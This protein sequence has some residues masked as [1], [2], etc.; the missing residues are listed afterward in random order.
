M[1]SKCSL[2]MAGLPDLPWDFPRQNSRNLLFLHRITV[3]GLTRINSDAQSLQIFESKDQNSRSPFLSIGFFDLRL[4]TATCCL[5]ARSRIHA[6][7]LNQA[8]T[9][10]KRNCTITIMSKIFMPGA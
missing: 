8:K 7:L 3:S 9:I 4:Y 10:N 2:G 5:S 1:K 6:V